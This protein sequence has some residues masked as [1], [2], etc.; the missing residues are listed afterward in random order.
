VLFL[1]VPASKSG[2]KAS[3]FNFILCG[4]YSIYE[5]LRL[6]LPVGWEEYLPKIFTLYFTIFFPFHNISM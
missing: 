3:C 1:E 5:M 6:P 2:E 4:F